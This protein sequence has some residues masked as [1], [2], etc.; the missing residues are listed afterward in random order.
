MSV[1]QNIID[2]MQRIGV[3]P[4]QPS[5]LST[6]DQLAE[7]EG[8]AP[9]HRQEIAAI[10]G[11][12][13]GRV[14]NE[15]R[16]DSH[17]SGGLQVIPSTGL[18]YVTPG[19]W[20][21]PQGKI[22]A[23][24]RYYKS[25]LNAFPGDDQFDQRAAAYHAGIGAVQ[26]A[27]ASGQRLPHTEDRYV[28]RQLGRP[29]FTDTDYVPTVLARFN[30][31]NGN[32]K[33]PQNVQDEIAR[34]SGA[35]LSGSAHEGQQPQA[36]PPP[37]A[38][39]IAR[40][41]QSS[42]SA[43][44]GLQTQPTPSTEANQV[45]GQPS[46]FTVP[47][48]TTRKR[49]A[50]DEGEPEQGTL[51][52]NQV[53]FTP[54]QAV[55]ATPGTTLP[56]RA[57]QGQPTSQP[58]ASTASPITTQLTPEQ[59]YVVGT[60]LGEA[61]DR[62]RHETFD[63]AAFEQ[64]RR[65]NRIPVPKTDE[66]RR[67]TQTLF[68][69]VQNSDPDA[70]ATLNKYQADLR[71]RDRI[72][73]RN[74]PIRRQ[75]Q[76]GSANGGEP[77][78]GEVTDADFVKYLGTLPGESA[79]WSRPQLIQAAFTVARRK[80]AG[81]AQ[82][83]PALAD[84]E[85]AAL[86]EHA[87]LPASPQTNNRPRSPLAVPP[88]PSI[89]FRRPNRPFEFTAR[90]EEAARVQASGQQIRAALQLNSVRD[91]V[92]QQM[93]HEW[94]YDPRN[95]N[96]M[97]LDDGAIERRIN[98]MREATQHEE[99]LRASLSPEQHQQ[100]QE[101]AQGLQRRFSNEPGWLSALDTG[102][103]ISASNTATLIPGV[104]RIIG[105]VTGSQRIKQLA[106]E[107]E[108]YFAM[109]REAHDI[110]TRG[111]TDTQSVLTNGA[112]VVSDVVQLAAL[113]EVAGPV[114]AMAALGGLE[115]LGGGQSYGR[116][117]METVKG[118]GYGAMFGAAAR[119]RPFAST[120]GLL[121][122]GGD[123]AA[124][125]GTVATGTYAIERAFGSSHQE[126]MRAAMTNT[127]LSGVLQFTGTVGAGVSEE[128]RMASE[129][130]GAVGER[131]PE[132]VRAAIT[133]ARGRVP[134]YVQEESGG[135]GGRIGVVNAEPGENGSG[136]IEHFRPLTYEE[137]GQVNPSRYVTVSP[138]EFDAMV[139]TFDSSRG[140]Q[141]LN[142]TPD[143]E[144]AQGSMPQEPGATALVRRE[145]ASPN[146]APTPNQ[147]PSAPQP[148]PETPETINAQMEAF[149]AGRRKAILVTPGE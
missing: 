149:V 129:G 143:L 23:G 20:A 84:M 125:L 85:R 62:Q 131:L 111:Q 55:I 53:T 71:R 126:A 116:A 39:E 32:S 88:R 104:W 34:I 75:S 8:L 83:V 145:G 66:E 48:Y 118:A 3:R 67:N 43:Q 1:P 140:E 142:Q 124:H 89:D 15:A 99:E 44:A 86:R 134:V 132:N 97:P 16:P 11:Q 13:S 135:E 25:I 102:L 60:A 9:R 29:Y 128:A 58:V 26:H 68:A 109:R 4:P 73:R 81:E 12:E 105:D 146:E 38:T 7:E 114:K 112:R 14:T 37:I 95:H 65:R 33:P 5:G 42:T 127:I 64:W 94:E 110:S 141:I 100:A 101:I 49:R 47:T 139:E 98:Q 92:R 77:N 30:G 50:T 137:V 78:L 24:L 70:V 138:E 91:Q 46:P 119:I 51:E 120:E 19:E 117:A 79:G 40:I 93:S 103:D 54:S 17:A 41:N 21:T 56:T 72:Q 123:L 121:A 36:T 22:R 80:Q 18:H 76:A 27:V 144:P 10:G 147:A 35:P 61:A 106:R 115:S 31:S 130:R 96:A 45:T 57:A 63:Q 69:N 148:T 113:S 107:G 2:E 74:E 133:R 82:S 136:R 108:Q 6:I 87:G 52:P 122:R 28:S 90:G 59:G